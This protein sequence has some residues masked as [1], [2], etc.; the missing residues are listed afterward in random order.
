M[1]YRILLTN[2]NVDTSDCESPYTRCITINIKYSSSFAMQFSL[3]FF[4]TRR[5][6]HAKV[7]TAFW[8]IGNFTSNKELPAISQARSLVE[9][10]CTWH[11]S[12]RL[13][14]YH[15]LYWRRDA[16]EYI[17]ICASTL[18]SIILAFSRLITTIVRFAS[19][20]ACWRNCTGT[21]P[22]LHRKHTSRTNGKT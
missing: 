12:R 6:Y 1:I 20:N 13:V 4:R 22:P 19:R 18:L 8:F 16:K 3:F 11:T 7:T 9:F 15:S 17:C 14:I 2:Q 10:A 5:V 21:F